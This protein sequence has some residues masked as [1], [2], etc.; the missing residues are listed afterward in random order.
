MSM[1][2][3]A[4]TPAFIRLDGVYKV[5]RVGD[6]GVAALGGVSFEVARGEFAAIVGPSGAGKSTILN[7]IGG[8]D[9]PTAGLV[10]V[11]GMDL[12]QLDS[13]GLSDYR[14]TMVG[15][16]WQGA[17]KNLI[18]YLTVAQNVELPL[19]LAGLRSA[20]DQRRR[21]GQLLELMGLGE[22]ARHF[23]RCSPA[24]NSS[25]PGWPWPSRTSRPSCSPMNPLRRSTPKVRTNCSRRCGQPARS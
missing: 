24:A 12:A 22:R 6:V 1:Q 18:P 20:A 21:T 25:A 5:H 23:R 10:S 14:S 16:L 13:A 17:T 19:L 11:A 8:V 7:L 9:A 2:I 4:E 15:F 3:E